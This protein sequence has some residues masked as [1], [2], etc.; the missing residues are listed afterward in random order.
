MMRRVL[1]VAALGVFSAATLWFVAQT[2]GAANLDAAVEALW[3]DGGA[4]VALIRYTLGDAEESGL[5]ALSALAL[6]QTPML[7]AQ[8]QAVAE[9]WSSELQLLPQTDG[10]DDEGTVLSAPAAQPGVSPVR[11]NGVPARTLRP[12]DDSGYTLLGG[13]YV[14]NG[15][16]CT[17][18]EAP[19]PQTE[20]PVRVLILHTHATESYTMPEGEEYEQTDPCRTLDERYNMLR[21]G[22]EIAQVLESRGIEVIHD[23]GIY[24]YPR[25]SGAYT[26]SLA[27][28]EAYLSQEEGLYYILDV[29]RD[30]VTDTQGNHYK[31]VCAEAE[32]TAQIEFVVGTPGGG[33]EHPLWQQN[34]ALAAAV[35]RTLT[36]EY[37][38]LMRPIVLRN[39]R[40]NQHLTP[41]TLLVEIGTAGNS[42][43]EAINAAR[44]FAEGF[45]ETILSF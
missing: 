25:Y 14:N 41:G 4:A 19:L 29:H 26:R 12:S 9:V 18:E 35:Q 44:L 38:T 39:A 21:I 10:E 8:R 24:D 1:R 33:A 17:V 37:P 3:Q 20:A 30:A 27:A 36:R 42:L 13:V 15:S 5:D 34:L 32:D 22:E 2:A 40:Y 43:A 6:G 31:L 23:T 11:D 28:A 45:A 16:S 7:L